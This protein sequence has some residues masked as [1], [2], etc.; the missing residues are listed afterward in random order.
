MF[1]DYLFESGHFKYIYNNWYSNTWINSKKKIIGHT[2]GATSNIDTTTITTILIT[3]ETIITTTTTTSVIDKIA[4]D[5]GAGV[6]ELRIRCIRAWAE[7][8]III[9]IIITQ[10]MIQ[11]IIANNTPLDGSELAEWVGFNKYDDNFD[12]H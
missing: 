9:S 1:Q 2:A 3:I 7:A 6:S 10:T 4:S 5:T 12:Y 8:T 11:I